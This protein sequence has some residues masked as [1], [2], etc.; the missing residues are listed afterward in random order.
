M[1]QGALISMKSHCLGQ[2]KYSPD[3]FS[4][5]SGVLGG[6][7]RVKPS[8]FVILNLIQ[9]L[10]KI[11]S[12]VCFAYACD[13]THI[14]PSPTSHTKKHPCRDVLYGALGGIRTHSLLIRS[15]MLYPV[16]LRARQCPY[17]TNLFSKMQA[18]FPKKEN[19]FPFFA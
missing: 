11:A 10:Q 19:N 15:Q 1:R 5:L 12:G 13:R 4:L 16:E 2:K 14:R 7:V 6:I 3:I 18:L 8:S 17:Y 9:N